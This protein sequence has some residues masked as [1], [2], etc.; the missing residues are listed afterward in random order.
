MTVEDA[1]PEDVPAI[2]AIYAA[3]TL[4]P[5]TFDLEGHPVA[6]WQEVLDAS[7]PASGRHLFTA[8]DGEQVL[9]Y[10]RSGHHRAKP[11][12][13][14]TCETSVYVAVEHRGRGVGDA[15]YAALLGR[16]DAGPL[17]LAVAGVTLPNP[18]SERLHLAHGFTEVGVFHSV[19]FKLGRPWDVRWFQRPLAR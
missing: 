13:D 10:A 17:R 9:G 6:W 15:L 2:A 4:T 1:R 7:D 5:A 11:A 3:A 14:T 19:G 16:L 18:A 8:R 12:Y